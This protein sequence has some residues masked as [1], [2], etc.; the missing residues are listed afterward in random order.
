MPVPDQPLHVVL[1]LQVRS[2]MED[3]GL[4]RDR[5]IDPWKLPQHPRSPLGHTPGN[6]WKGRLKKVTPLTARTEI[7]PLSKNKVDAILAHLLEP[8]C[9]IHRFP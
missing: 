1:E 9:S 8:K 5:D 7:T 6:P 2:S 4:S 3:V